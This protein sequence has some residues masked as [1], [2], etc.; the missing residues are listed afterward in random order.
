MTGSTENFVFDN[1]DINNDEKVDAAD[2]V[3]FVN[4]LKE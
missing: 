4:L 1:A 2:L 3:M